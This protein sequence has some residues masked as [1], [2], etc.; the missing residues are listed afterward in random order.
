MYSTN[1]KEFE[2]VWCFPGIPVHSYFVIPN[3]HAPLIKICHTPYKLDINTLEK[4]HSPIRH[5]TIW[6]NVLGVIVKNIIV[7]FEKATLWNKFD[8]LLAAPVLQQASGIKL[9]F[10]MFGDQIYHELLDWI[11]VLTV[12]PLFLVVFIDG[13]ING[14]DN[15]CLI[16]YFLSYSQLFTAVRIPIRE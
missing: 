3:L 7:H 1:F 15:R 6:F 4:K 13:I 12:S 8:P 2:E 5:R 16:I 11:L 9:Y 10:V 14:V